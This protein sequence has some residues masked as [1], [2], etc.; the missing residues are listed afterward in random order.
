MID[1]FTMDKETRTLYLTPEE[2]S[3]IAN[4][5]GEGMTGIVPPAGIRENS[6]ESKKILPEAFIRKQAPKT[7]S[8]K[9]ISEDDLIFDIIRL[10]TD[11]VTIFPDSS[12]PRQT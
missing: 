5:A 9:G 6:N 8:M 7:D 11:G 3:A 12:Q 2:E 10:E 1:F 4:A